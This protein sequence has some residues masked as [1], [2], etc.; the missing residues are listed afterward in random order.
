MTENKKKFLEFMSTL[1]KE[2]IE[3]ITK[4]EK[5]ELIVFAA[6][7]GFTLTDADF[8][9]SEGEVSL[10]EAEAVAGGGECYCTF[11]GGGTAEGYDNAC[12]CVIAGAGMH[13]SGSSRY[14][15]CYCGVM[16]YGVDCT[17]VGQGCV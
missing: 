6:D 7:R 3:K 14:N 4:M 5:D 1:D 12:A 10:D 15:R 2:T 11:G 16:G 8:E 9:Q 13:D 17:V